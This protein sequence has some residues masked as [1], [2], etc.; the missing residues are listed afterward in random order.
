VSFAQVVEPDAD[1]MGFKNSSTIAQRSLKG[2]DGR[3]KPNLSIVAGN[4]VSKV[5]KSLIIMTWPG[6]VVLFDDVFSQ[7]LTL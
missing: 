3:S 1:M 6:I 4:S 2:S 5:L 7:S